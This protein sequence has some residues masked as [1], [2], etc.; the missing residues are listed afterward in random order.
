MDVRKHRN[1]LAGA[2]ASAGL[3][4]DRH[5]GTELWL[6]KINL[7]MMATHG[8]CSK[9]IERCLAALLGS[10]LTEIEPQK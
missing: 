6:A 2:G 4:E 3:S 7:K 1:L 8:L 9:K 5:L 10:I